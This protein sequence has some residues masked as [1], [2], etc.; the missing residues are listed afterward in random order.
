MTPLKQSVLVT[1]PKP[2]G[3][4]LCEAIRAH[5]GKAVY[6]PTVDIEPPQDQAGLQ[7]QINDLAQYDWLIFLSP[8][9]VYQSM[10]M[11]HARWPRLPDHAQIAAV[12]GGTVA[13]LNAAGMNVDACPENDWSSEGLL[14]LPELQAVAGKKIALFQGEGGR[15][16]LAESLKERGAILAEIIA[17]RRVL[18]QVDVTKYVNLIRQKKMD[19]VICASGEAV[20]NLKK[21]LGHE[22]WPNLRNMTLVVVSQRIA[23]I[24]TELGFKKIVIAKNASDA[25]II[26]KLEELSMPTVS[27][28]KPQ[29]TRQSFAWDK[30]GILFSMLGVIVSLGLLYYVFN[31]LMTLNLTQAQRINHLENNLT[32]LQKET[33]SLT[34]SMNEQLLPLR[35]E[36]GKQ[37]QLLTNLSA[38]HQTSESQWSV[39]EAASLIKLANDHLQLEENIPLAI[40]LLQTADQ[41]LSQN[42]DPKILMIR[43]AIAVDLASLQSVPQ[44]DVA[45][46]Y[47]RV[48]A[49]ND[50]VDHLTPALSLMPAAT[51]KQTA[52]P[53]KD[54]SLPW[55]KKGLEHSW[56]QLKKIVVVRYMPEQ[57]LP[58]LM[59]DQQIYLY[60]NIHAAFEKALWA[61]LHKQPVIYQASLQQAATWITK[62]FTVNAASTAMLNAIKELQ[63]INLHPPM[64]KTLTSVSALQN[65]FAEMKQVTP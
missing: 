12:G 38:S 13:A 45:T 20:Q 10:P 54:Q 64:T 19:T 27:E 56:H 51:E 8:Q 31:Q 26:E 28:V 24:A 21:M 30:I 29:N 37:N 42:P 52:E 18:P 57:T 9:A 23:D 3:Q 36:L 39:Q 63:Q 11:I 48:S 7:Q 43:K 25:A 40:K 58:L 41:T 34:K 35:E 33:P 1:R 6:F 47:M 55:W 60:Q 2:Q 59:P 16:L 65:Y 62:Y 15:E 44:V 22:Q 61:V 46:I 14:A 17:Y 50:Q 49:L 5:G 53:N 32:Q 4:L